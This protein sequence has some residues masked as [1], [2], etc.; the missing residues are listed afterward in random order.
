MEAE[1]KALAA[2]DPHPLLGDS[3]SRQ[4]QD[5]LA[6]PFLP[7]DEDYG[8]ITV[9]AERRKPV[10]TDAGGVNEFVN[11]GETGCA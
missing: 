9:E 1:L 11:H 2:N 7:Y 3:D 6:V 10:T 8:L 4:Y 5:A